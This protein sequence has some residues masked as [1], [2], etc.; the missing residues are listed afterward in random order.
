MYIISLRALLWSLFLS[1]S[2]CLS[3][4]AHSK[5]E[6]VLLLRYTTLEGKTIYLPVR[7]LA[8]G[9]IE[10]G[11]SAGP[12]WGTDGM[13]KVL[14]VLPK[15]DNPLWSSGV[16]V[17]L[18]EFPKGGLKQVNNA[19]L[20]SVGYFYRDQES[21]LAFRFGDQNE[22]PGG[23]VHDI[24][25]QDS[26]GLKV[27]PTR[28]S[29]VFGN[30]SIQVDYGKSLSL[31]TVASH[32]FPDI[33][34][35]DELAQ[36][37]SKLTKS[38]DA[39]LEGAMMT[40]KSME[41]RDGFILAGQIM[42]F[43]VHSLPLQSIH[44]P[45]QVFQVY[46]PREGEGENGVLNI[47]TYR[48]IPELGMIVEPFTLSEPNNNRYAL[49]FR[50]DNKGL[51]ISL[52]KVIEGLT[53]HSVMSARP[54]SKFSI[55][56]ETTGSIGTFD[57]FG[58]ITEFLNLGHELNIPDAQSELINRINFTSLLDLSLLLQPYIGQLSPDF[59]LN[60]EHADKIKTVINSLFRK[61][62]FARLPPVISKVTLADKVEENKIRIGFR[63]SSISVKQIYHPDDSSL[64]MVFGPV[65]LITPEGRHYYVFHMTKQ[66]QY[67]FQTVMVR[68]SSPEEVWNSL[69]RQKMTG[70]SPYLNFARLTVKRGD[71]SNDAEV[72]LTTS[73]EKRAVSTWTRVK[74]PDNRSVF[75][76]ELKGQ[77]LLPGLAEIIQILGYASCTPGIPSLA[78]VGLTENLLNCDLEAYSSGCYPCGA[79]RDWGIVPN[80]TWAAAA[81]VT[82]KIIR[83]AWRHKKKVAVGTAALAVYSWIQANP[84]AA[85]E[86][87]SPFIPGLQE[88]MDSLCPLFCRLFQRSSYCGDV[89]CTDDPST[90]LPRQC[91]GGTL[92]PIK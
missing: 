43:A 8:P 45:Q 81:T 47:L 78:P 5:R 28:S 69:I 88:I 90:G 34:D 82:G 24:S 50:R 58:S 62:L 17:L 38:P 46:L 57:Q 53:E 87:I 59:T 4:S 11:F 48:G 35:R 30:H 26:Y 68:S 86:A 20:L 49:H 89:D 85:E 12:I 14:Q 10:Q 21:K 42:S 19:R 1:F 83:G 16:E 51:T 2:L 13:A 15:N 54:E 33:P 44:F 66:G 76:T 7:A 63:D 73:H 41:N 60:P 23:N 92:P 65:Y 31:L 3:T 74:W 25:I 40:T 84:E 72:T 22:S 52:V 71:Y 67:E 36:G 6:F 39:P 75:L 32:K 55:N 29:L 18:K 64:G 91:A 56:L 9:S 70:I 77:T 37:M 61:H 27:Q 79:L 80:Q